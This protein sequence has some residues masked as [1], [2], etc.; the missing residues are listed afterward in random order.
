[1]DIRLLPFWASVISVLSLA[2]QH[3]IIPST[4]VIKHYDRVTLPYHLARLV[5][6]LLLAILAIP[7]AQ[8]LIT[9]SLCVT[10]VCLT[11]LPGSSHITFIGLHRYTG[12]IAPAPETQLRHQTSQCNPVHNLFDLLVQ[13]C[14]SPCNF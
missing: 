14:L 8:D 7:S 6:C 11:F 9:Q 3:L 2:L 12:C 5:G 13:R 1:M 4:E 10:F